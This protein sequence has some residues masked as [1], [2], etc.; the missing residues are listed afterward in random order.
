MI[1]A[2]K[3][4]VN[5]RFQVT[6]LKRAHKHDPCK[7][8][9]YRKSIQCS[10]EYLFSW[11]SNSRGQINLIAS[12]LEIYINYSSTHRNIGK[13][14]HTYCY[15]NMMHTQ[16]KAHYTKYLSYTHKKISTFTW[17]A[18]KFK[19]K[20]SHIHHFQAHIYI[21]YFHIYRFHF[22]IHYFTS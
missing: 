5:K 2:I 11:N 10:L 22:Q 6:L 20:Y 14:S 13:S 15:R 8:S 7:E 3:S 21:K 12:I 1:S 9:H 18:L 4:E 19:S 17:N 16:K